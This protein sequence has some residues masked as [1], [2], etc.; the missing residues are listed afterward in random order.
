MAPDRAPDDDGAMNET[1]G[2]S[3]A[4]DRFD[5][6]RARTLADVRRPREDRLIAGVGTGIGRH[7]GIDPVIV[8]V[9]LAVLCLA[10]LAGVVLYAAAWLLLPAEDAERSIVGDWFD[11]RDNERQ[12]RT[13]GLLVAGVLA[14]AAIIGDTSLGWFFWPLAF[15]AFWLGIPVAIGYWLLVVRPRR[16]HQ[17]TQPGTTAAAAPPTDPVRTPSTSTATQEL[18]MSTAPPVDAWSTTSPPP[19]ATAPPTAAPPPRPRRPFSWALTLLTLSVTAIAVALLSLVGPTD[20]LRWTAY[21]ALALA[22]TGAG[23]LVGTVVG[24]AGPL[25]PVGL[26]LA[27]ALVVGS[28]VPSLRA[29]DP[30]WAPVVAADVQDEYRLGMGLLTLDLTDVEDPDALQGRTVDLTHGLGETL[31]VIPEG[32]DVALEA[33]LLVGNV[34]FLGEQQNGTF[35]DVERRSARTGPV[36][37]LRVDQSMGQVRVIRR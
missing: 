17:A 23:L 1:T 28:L 18:T 19:A 27:A 35:V 26:L 30:T 37:T 11:L 31:V 20:E 2:T 4:R 8:R 12:V 21:V 32:L 13:T 7:L 5:P 15:V 36:L 10:G 16:R 33:D 29:G 25:I 34:D 14:L 24:N 6:G 9:V 3:E 22:I